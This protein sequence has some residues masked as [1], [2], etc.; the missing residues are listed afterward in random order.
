M[1]KNNTHLDDLFAAARHEEPVITQKNAGD[2]LSQSEH[3]QSAPFIFST[4]GIIMSTIGLSAAAITAYIMLSGSPQLPSQ[5]ATS[6]NIPVV[7]LLAKP[8]ESTT[9]PKIQE[10]KQPRKYIVV[11][12]T[13][14]QVLPTPAIPTTLPVPPSTPAITTPVKVTGIKPITITPDKI[15][16]MG[17]TKKD[18]GTVTFSQKNEKGRIFSMSF[19]KNT[20]GIIVGDKDKEKQITDAPKFAPLIVT[21]TKGNKRLMQFSGEMNGMKMKALQIQSHGGDV[22]INTED[23]DEAVDNALKISGQ[24]QVGGD[25]GDI[26]QLTVGSLDSNQLKEIHSAINSQVKVHITHND[27]DG[28]SDNSKNVQ[29]YINT[30]T[31]G[32]SDTARFGNKKKIIVMNRDIRIDSAMSNANIKMNNAE[33]ELNQ[34]MKKFKLDNLD[35]LNTMMKGLDLNMKDV[36]AQMKVLDINL[37]ESMKQMENFS[38]KLDHLVPILVRSSTSD[39]FDKTEGITYDDGLI[40]W[41]DPQKE[42]T[43]VVPEATAE[44]EKSIPQVQPHGTVSNV[45]ITTSIFPNPAREKT[46]IRFSLSEPRDVGFS[47]HDLLGKRVAESGSVSAA[48]SGDYVH[49]IDVRNLKAGVYLIVLTTDKGEQSIQRLVIEK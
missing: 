25:D 34:V 10:A 46:M 42:F 18:D 33:L 15:A 28:N 3:M 32:Q 1:N 26:D 48:S 40:F 36:D 5:K 37:A 6:V 49:E 19:P 35:S 21:D 14:E 44:V 47:I 20:W 2:L 22:D 23:I 9:E 17:I 24:L 31:N 13:D 41:Y 16:K 43:D 29:V 8:V 39:H 7:N 30:Q 38:V 12:R 4:K 45:I 27:G 11:T